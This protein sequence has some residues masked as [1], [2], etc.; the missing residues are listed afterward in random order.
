MMAMDNLLT[1]AS[2]RIVAW[3]KYLIMI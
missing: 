3:H 2:R 1:M